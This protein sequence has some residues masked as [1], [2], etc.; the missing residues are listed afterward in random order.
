MQLLPSTAR[1]IERRFLD[2]IVAIT[3]QLHAQGTIERI[4]GRPS[5]DDG[6]E[7][8]TGLDVVRIVPPDELAELVP[9]GRAANA[10]W[11][12][13]VTESLRAAM[14]DWILATAAKAHTPRCPSS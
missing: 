5:I 7:A 8:V 4:F 12:P 9:K 13:V 14:L 6:G 3:Q 11:E 10:A 2:L 1:H